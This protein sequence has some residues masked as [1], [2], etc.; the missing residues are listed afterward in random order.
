[1]TTTPDALVQ[2]V[3]ALLNAAKPVGVTVLDHDMLPTEEDELPVIGVY[4]ADDQALDLNGTRTSG[5]QDR[6]ATLRC[7]CRAVGPSILAGTLAL[8]S[9]VVATLTDDDSLGG[10][11]N[12]LVFKGFQPFGRASDLRFCG[13]DLDFDVFYIFHP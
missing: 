13:A 1:M 11:A 8:R 7:E 2:R 5:S 3:F 6:V 4:L 9:F 12:A 10:L